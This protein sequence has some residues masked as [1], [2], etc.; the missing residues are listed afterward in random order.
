MSTKQIPKRGEVWIAELDPTKGSEIKKTRVTVI[1]SSDSVGVLPVKLV[2]PIRE[3]KGIFTN[4]I[5]HVKIEPNSTN[6]LS[7]TSSVDTLQ[8]RGLDLLRFK[9]KV[10]ELSAEEMEEITVAIAA[11][12]EY[13]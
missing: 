13:Q 3:W 4:D 2:A 7:K 8:L 5:W 11:V 6:G 1:V 12:I 10:G 9:K